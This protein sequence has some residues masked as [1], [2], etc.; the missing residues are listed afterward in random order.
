MALFHK[1]V[2]AASPELPQISDVVV[3]MRKRVQSLR[4]LERALALHTNE[5]TA[6]VEIQLTQDLSDVKLLENE[7]ASLRQE[8]HRKAELV[9]LLIAKLRRCVLEDEFQDIKM[10]L[11]KLDPADMITRK[12]FVG[13]LQEHES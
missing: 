4:D 1:R 5:R 7:F 9:N 3:S 13:L 11:E 8:I 10:R 12:E 2:T 6:S